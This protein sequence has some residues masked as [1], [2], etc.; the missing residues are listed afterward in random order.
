MQDLV[1]VKF[2]I[3]WDPKGLLS[4]SLGFSHLKFSPDFRFSHWDVN[5]EQLHEAWY[6]EKL[7]QPN[8]LSWMFDEFHKMV[9]SAQLFVNDFF[10]FATGLFTQVIS[11]YT[12]SLKLE[13]IA[14]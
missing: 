7:S 10:V 14:N 2:Y 8:I 1:C 6:A 4:E 5:N 9:P 13:C 3:S 12:Q 11:F